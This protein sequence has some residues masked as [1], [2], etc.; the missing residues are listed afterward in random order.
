MAERRLWVV[1]SLGRVYLA[2]AGFTLGEGRGFMLAAVRLAVMVY[3][4]SP[5]EKLD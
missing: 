2:A 5:K 3:N 1:K 4:F